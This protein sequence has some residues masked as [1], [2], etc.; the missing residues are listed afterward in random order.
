MTQEQIYTAEEVAAIL[1][2][3]PRT[4]HRLIKRGELD[5]FTIS[6]EYRI[7]QSAL[8]EF[9]RRKPGKKREDQEP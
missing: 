3:H 4:I 1:R 8:D 5:A 7:R 6:G 9:M 2:V